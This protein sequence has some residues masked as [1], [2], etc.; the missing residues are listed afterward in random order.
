M[1]C[2]V[3]NFFF[4]SLTNKLA[5]VTVLGASGGI[6]QPLSLLLKLN[7]RIGHLALYDVSKAMHPAKGVAADVSDINTLAH[8][9]GYSGDE[10]LPKALIGADVVVMAA[11]VPRKPGMT[12]D[13]LFMINASIAKSLAD[14][15]KLHAPPTCIVPIITNPVNS[16]VP[17][18]NGVLAAPTRVMGIT[19]LDVIR[20]SRI[21]GERVN[22]DPRE[23][24]IPV[25][26]GHAGL[27]IVPLFSQA[28]P[29]GISKSIPQEEISI[30]DK[31]VQDAGT[32]VVEAKNGSGSA[33]LSMAYAASRFVDA[34]LRGLT[35][36]RGVVE[37]CYADSKEGYF[38]APFILGKQ[39]LEGQVPPANLNDYEKMRIDEAKTKLE[40]DIKVGTD[41][42]KSKL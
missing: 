26:G 16:I 42:L 4:M 25:V 37:C 6:G 23:I 21:L 24:Q 39:G 27:T 11:G 7:P 36:D 12:R 15:I 18:V 29:L 35:G 17:I 41:F 30:L 40:S 32:V 3:R 28:T 22:R 33:T 13:D 14:A 10:E 5:K 34:I 2:L 31:M 8:V 20:A 38:A 9:S 19:T 1:V